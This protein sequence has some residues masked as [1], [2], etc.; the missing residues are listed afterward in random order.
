MSF[1]WQLKLASSSII[2]LNFKTNFNICVNI[3]CEKVIWVEQIRGFPRRTRFT[4]ERMSFR[5]IPSHG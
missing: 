3:E 4:S 5:K 1:L 2:D